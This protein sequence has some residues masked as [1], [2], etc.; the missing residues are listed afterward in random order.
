[1]SMILNGPRGASPEAIPLRAGPLTMSFEPATLLLRYLR[2]GSHEV[3]RGVYVAVRDH[4][5][6]TVPA[7]VS[8]L[9]LVTRGDA[10]VLS[11]E[12]RHDDGR[13]AFDWRGEI[14][15]S[16]DG[17]VRYLI[18]GSAERAF[19]RNRIGFCVLHPVAE[20]AGER[21]E[22]EHV[23]GSRENAFFPRAIAPQ[24]Y[25]DGL[26]R[27]HEPFTRLRSMRHQVVPG[28]WAT[29]TFEGDTFELEDQRNW[30]DASFKTYGTPL[31]LP[32]P[33]DL[34]AGAKVSQSVTV[35]LGAGGLAKAERAD[36]GVEVVLGDA[37][38][39]LP[40]IG[41][42]LAS[43]GFALTPL[44]AAR[45]APLR[46][47]HLR[48]DVRAGATDRR[49]VIERAHADAETLN[50]GLE[51]A[52][53]LG[54]DPERELAV[55]AEDLAVLGPRV[56][57]W[58]I[59]RRGEKR[60]DTRWVAS[61]RSQLAPLAPGAGFVAGTDAYFAELNRDRPPVDH[62]DGLCYSI[63][64][65]VHA[66][67]DAT[68]VESLEAQ[69]ETVRSAVTFAD[70][71]PIVVS[72]ITLRPRFNPNATGPE[73]EPAPGSLPPQVD[74]RQL[75]LFGA[76]WT[77][78]SIKHLAEAGASSLTYFETAGWRGVME[79]GAGSPLPGLFPSE[80][81]TVFPLYHVFADV[82]DFA[83]GEVVSSRSSRPL[84]VEALALRAGVRTRVLVANF[85]P[86]V[87]GVVV[88]FRGAPPAVRVGLLDADAAVA[89][90][91]DP[92][93]FR[94]LP[95]A[96]Q[97]LA[98]GPLRVCLPP[99]AVARIDVEA[100]DPRSPREAPKGGGPDVR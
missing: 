67:D 34:A 2:L 45:L 20:C 36:D 1:M 13:V 10:F 17:E 66:F 95:G 87:R 69:G 58:L 98:G 31:E 27:P 32:F 19:R 38:G 82:G 51:V 91:R 86:K 25:V 74:P 6:D 68:L 8:N 52:L 64:P 62:L 56:A 44:E 4:N 43:D 89:A 79:R 81:D 93:G 47:A 16:A 37:A 40:P 77:L 53:H 71:R 84:E 80:P 29:V 88:R 35:D 94:S 3:L 61:A 28:V 60:T 99:Y 54:E 75:S 59:F 41:L 85:S 78:A 50:C 26:P 96:R 46:L 92:E 70:R 55:L 49:A 97:E 73:P 48:C 83:G 9:V 11:F 5:W 22:L 21:C 72:P 24:P 76:G 7:R 15:G 57:R 12:A 33:V 30:T 14:A 90:G 65:Q 100:A 39:P 42:G 23:D 63:N 18:D